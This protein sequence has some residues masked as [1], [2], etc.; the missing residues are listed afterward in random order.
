MN[1]SRKA[2]PTKKHKQS[3]RWAVFFAVLVLIGMLGTV[4]YFWYP[5]NSNSA[6]NEPEGFKTITTHYL[7]VMKNLNSSQTKSEMATQLDP[8]YN[9]T[10]LFA[11]E[12]SKLTF[13]NAAS[14]SEDPMQILNS[15]D[16]IC[17]QWSIVYVSACLSLGYQAG[18]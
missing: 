11:W 12:A 13:Q 18:L 5:T 3:N 10:D 6:N 8:K 16:G 15:G 14:W 2:H 9:Q 4:A 1:P 17:V 7:D